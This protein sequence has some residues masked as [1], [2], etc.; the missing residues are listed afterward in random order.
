MGER[1]ER[2]NVKAKVVIPYIILT[3]IGFIVMLYFTMFFNQAITRNEIQSYGVISVIKY[4]FSSSIA[5]KLFLILDAGVLLGVSVLILSNSKGYQSDQMVITPDL[6][7]PVP[8]G[9]GQCGTARW[10][11]IL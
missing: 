7:T 4:V 6:S 9:Q 8:A 1:I 5:S 3:L 10:L 2:R 11:R